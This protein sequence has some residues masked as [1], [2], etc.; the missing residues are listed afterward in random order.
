M[1]KFVNT[2]LCK[3]K[4]LFKNYTDQFKLSRLSMFNFSKRFYEKR[5]KIKDYLSKDKEKYKKELYKK[6]KKYDNTEN[7]NLDESINLN[8]V[9]MLGAIKDSKNKKWKAKESIRVDKLNKDTTVNFG[10]AFYFIL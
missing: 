2:T 9:E 8:K 1:F 3:E 6:K 4:F 7:F 10:Y 5:E